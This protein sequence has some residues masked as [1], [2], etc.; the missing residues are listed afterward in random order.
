MFRLYRK[1][2]SNCKDSLAPEIIYLERVVFPII[3]GFREYF[4]KISVGEAQMCFSEEKASC[5]L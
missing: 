1:N 4:R 3:R 2:L 5:C